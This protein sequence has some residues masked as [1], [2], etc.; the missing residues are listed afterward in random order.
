M[1]Y[2]KPGHSFLD[3]ES[4]FVTVEFSLG[5]SPLFSTI[6]IK[7]LSMSPE[8]SA[9]TIND[10]IE[11]LLVNALDATL[12]LTPIFFQHLKIIKTRLF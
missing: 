3:I 2:F 7:I 11:S 10:L 1:S 4:I 9:S 6:K 5:S 12:T 8:F